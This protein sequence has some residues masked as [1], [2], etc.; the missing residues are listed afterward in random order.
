MKKAVFT[1]AWQIKNL[2]NLSFSDALSWAWHLCKETAATVV[3]I[4]KKDGTT[5][6]RVVSREWTKYSEPKGGA[7]LKEGLNIFADLAKVAGQYIKG[8]F[9]LSP[10]ISTYKFQVAA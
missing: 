8:T 3:M 10:I 1:L 9:N 7:P 6:K 4:F 2:F 5:S